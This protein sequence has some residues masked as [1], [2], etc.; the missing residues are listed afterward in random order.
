MSGSVAELAQRFQGPVVDVDELVAA[1][2][3]TGINDREAARRYGAPSVFALGEQVL[4]HLRRQPTP[5]RADHRPPPYLAGAL[6]R[7]ALL[8]CALLPLVLLSDRAPVLAALVLFPLVRALTPSGLARSR[9]PYRSA[10]DLAPVEPTR[11]GGVSSRWPLAP[12][13]RGLHTDT[14]SARRA[15]GRAARGL[16]GLVEAAAIALVWWTAPTLQPLLVAVPL[17]EILVAWHRSR[18]TAGLDGYEDLR[19]FR[20]EVRGLAAV[21]VG[22]LVPPLVAGA[23]LGAAAYRLPY[24]L[25]AHPQARDLVL[26]MAA[27]MLLGGLLAVT[28]LLCARGR[29]LAAAVVAA[30]PLAGAAVVAWLLH[31]A[32]PGFA[33]LPGVVVAI[34]VAYLLGLVVAAH[35]TFDPD[36]YQ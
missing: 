2:E 25:S 7:A 29:T 19:A 36:E 15:R 10:N 21:T 31:A 6:G 26:G 30:A 16:V 35:S 4:G 22:A 14:S 23:A 18:A 12:G 11:A 3:A 34:G 8:V 32:V 24:R 5:W 9:A 28:G 1:L 20:R 33:V 27:A 17:A 13:W